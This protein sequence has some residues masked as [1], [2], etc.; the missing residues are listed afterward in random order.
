MKKSFSI[1]VLILVMTVFQ[2]CDSR[3]V[4]EEN[5]PIPN[6][7]WE[8]DAIKSFEFEV[9]DTLSPI[10]LIINLRTTVDYPYQ[11]IYLFLYSEYPNGVMDKDTIEFL[12]AE[13]N[14][15]WFGENSG[16]I[17]E[18]TGMIASGGRFSTAGKYV[19]KIQHAM[20]EE[21]LM[22]VVDVGFRVEKSA[23]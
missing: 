22:E 23:I 3:K 17:V 14:G 12:L 6:N 18:F 19:F 9:E 4:Y 10:N 21:L 11:N 16:T 7:V 2:S 1:G 5:L 20:R 15:K 8:K 13:P